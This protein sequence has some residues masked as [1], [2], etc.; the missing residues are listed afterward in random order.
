MAYCTVAQVRG[1]SVNNWRDGML[2]GV[3]STVLSDAAVGLHIT[4]AENIINHYL[5]KRYTVP[6]TT[7]PPLIETLTID[8]AAYFIMRSLVTKDSQN[9]NDWVDDLL[10]TAK[11]ELKDLADGK[12]N[13][14]DS[15]GT[16]IAQLEVNDISSNRQGYTPVFDMDA[17]ENQNVDSDLLTDIANERD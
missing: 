5:S 1:T 17:V 14:L 12:R 2:I 6:F 16:P 7:V 3:T 8:I 13:L 10:K 4:R 11:E 9:K 15:S